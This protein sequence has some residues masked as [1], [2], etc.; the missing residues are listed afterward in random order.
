MIEKRILKIKNEGSLDIFIIKKLIQFLT[1]EV[2]T[3]IGA[4]VAVAGII[5][6]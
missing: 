6:V 5:L 3:S 2:G 4:I 1:D